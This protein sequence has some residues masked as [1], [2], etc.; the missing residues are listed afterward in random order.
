MTDDQHHELLTVIKRLPP[1][2]DVIIST[3]PNSIYAET[4]KGFRLV[5]YRSPTRH[6]QATEHLYMNYTNEEGLLHDYSFL[7]DNY[8]ERQQIKRK[9]T[10]EIK[11]LQRL[12]AT[13]RNAIVWAIQEWTGKIKHETPAVQLELPMMGL[14]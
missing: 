9:I 14:S 11:K 10:R 6:G 1:N 4:L 3:Y 5:E 7:G 12:P 13:E 2:V 8:T